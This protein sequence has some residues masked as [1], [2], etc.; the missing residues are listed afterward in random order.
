[1]EDTRG[2]S[3][4]LNILHMAVFEKYSGEGWRGESIR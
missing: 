1:M 3:M 2:R 4:F